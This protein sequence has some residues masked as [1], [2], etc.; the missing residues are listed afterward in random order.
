MSTQLDRITRKARS[1]PPS[2]E[3]NLW[4]P[5]AGIPH[6]GFYEGGRAQEANTSR[7]VPTP[8][9]TSLAPQKRVKS[10]LRRVSQSVRSTSSSHG[11]FLSNTALY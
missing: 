11:T 7:L 3:C 6:G 8:P 5:F 10:G 1:E 9:K 4:S 2:R